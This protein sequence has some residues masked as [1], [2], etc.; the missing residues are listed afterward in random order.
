MAS[1]I[2]AAQPS[3]KV[4]PG[5]D[6]AHTATESESRAASSQPP[7]FS[8]SPSFL[9]VFSLLVQLLWRRLAPAV[10]SSWEVAH[11]MSEWVWGSDQ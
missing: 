7:S 2:N 4:V 5:R 11:Q 1:G 8:T 3:R 10:D 9:I 6:A